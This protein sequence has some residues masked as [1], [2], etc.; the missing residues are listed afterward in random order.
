MIC[1]DLC[2]SRT[3]FCS[4][5]SVERTLRLIRINTARA[6]AR[7][8][9]LPTSP[10]LVY[11]LYDCLCSASAVKTNSRRQQC[12]LLHQSRLACVQ[13]I[14]AETGSIISF[15]LTVKGLEVGLIFCDLCSTIKNFCSE[16]TVERTLRL[17]RIH[18]ACEL[19]LGVRLCP[20]VLVLCVCCTTVCALHHQLRLSS[21]TQQCKL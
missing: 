7:S 9:T 15:Q 5:D 17:I 16:D 8:P 11:M 21:R 14:Q 1:C 6:V 18:T 3:I 19:L 13:L 12:R 10:C 4:K 20:Q 2:S